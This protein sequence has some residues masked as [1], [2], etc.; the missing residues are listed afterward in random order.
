[1]YALYKGDGHG[2]VHL[3]EIQEIAPEIGDSLPLA[4][5]MQPTPIFWAVL[6]TIAT[7]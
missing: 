1:V 3:L 5:M 2:E 4:E 7:N 6:L